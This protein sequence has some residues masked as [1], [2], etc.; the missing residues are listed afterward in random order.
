MDSGWQVAQL[1]DAIR[2]REEAHLKAI[3]QPVTRLPAGWSGPS[4]FIAPE[5]MLVATPQHLKE[6]RLA[7]PPAD[8]IPWYRGPERKG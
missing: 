5:S 8:F 1:I 6:A 2:E 3:P 4:E 7:E